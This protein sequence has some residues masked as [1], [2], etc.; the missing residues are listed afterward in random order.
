[1]HRIG[2]RG[3]ILACL[4]VFDFIWAWSLLD[5][6]TSLTLRSAPAFSVVINVLSPHVWGYLFIFVGVV[7]GVQVWTENDSYAYTAAIVIKILWLI[8]ILAA[9]PIAGVQTVR[10]LAFWSIITCWVFIVSR[11]PEPVELHE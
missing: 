1:M 7:C 4:S 9:F 2:F 3:G 5:P 8:Y 11:W 6:K 10:L